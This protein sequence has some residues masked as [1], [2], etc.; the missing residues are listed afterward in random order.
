MVVPVEEWSGPA[1]QIKV[2]EANKKN[3]SWKTDDHLLK[4]LLLQP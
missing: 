4:N 3:R 1:A 2:K